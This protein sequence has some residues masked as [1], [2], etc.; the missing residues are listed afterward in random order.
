MK[1]C[2]DRRRLSIC[3]VA[4]SAT[5]NF[6]VDAVHSLKKHK[7][8]DQNIRFLAFVA[9]PEG[10]RIFLEADPDTDVYAA[11][12]EDHTYIIPRRDI[13]GYHV[14]EQS[15][16]SVMARDVVPL[17]RFCAWFGDTS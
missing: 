12:L 4:M 8:S 2:E 13:A 6:A 14:L 11:A 16:Y 7:A 5:G 9:A 17:W 10:M 1:L 15:R 3:V